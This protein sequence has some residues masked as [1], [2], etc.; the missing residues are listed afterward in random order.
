MQAATLAQT[1][2]D[3]I[4][5]VNTKRQQLVP[6]R[7]ISMDEKNQITRVLL[8]TAPGSKARSQA[9]DKL[10]EE[11]TQKEDPPFLSKTYRNLWSKW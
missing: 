7:R 2:S 11:L 6:L 9:M 8:G 4:D 3:V 5:L 1:T 10:F